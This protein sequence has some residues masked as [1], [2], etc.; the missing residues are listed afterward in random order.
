MVNKKF[1]NLFEIKN[2]HFLTFLPY[3]VYYGGKWN[4]RFKKKNLCIKQEPLLKTGCTEKNRV[5][6]LECQTLSVKI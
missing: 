5:S 1:V 6:N 2:L 4:F 3:L